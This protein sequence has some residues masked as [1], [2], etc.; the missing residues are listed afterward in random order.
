[1]SL[2]ERDFYKWTQE[3]AALLKAGALSQIDV[4]NLIEEIE[5]MGRSE[6]RE[7]VHRLDVLISHML[8]WD[9]QPERRGRCWELT[10]QEERLKL[11]DHIDMNPSLKSIVDEAV[12]SAYCR[13]VLRSMRETGLSR[14]TFP[15]NCPY[16]IEWILGE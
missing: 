15:E 8:M 2:Y 5:S 3:Q 7:L 16:R 6:R 9:C 11:E 4:E 12:S 1:M 13:A 14:T 10:I